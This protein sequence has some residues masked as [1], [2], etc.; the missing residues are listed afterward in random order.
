MKKSLIKLEDV[1]NFIRCATDGLV[2]ELK[3]QFSDDED[4]EGLS[5]V[6]EGVSYS[7][8]EIGSDDEIDEG[9]YSYG[10]KYFQLCS[11]DEKITTYLSRKSEL[12]K[13]DIVVSQG[14]SKSGSYYS[15][16]EWYYDEPRASKIGVVIVPEVIIPEHEEVSFTEI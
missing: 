5:F 2:E 15:D 7:L 11:Y 13:F 10:R 3:E 16:Y 9:K 14:Y 6:Y 4:I 12:D 1:K 8:E